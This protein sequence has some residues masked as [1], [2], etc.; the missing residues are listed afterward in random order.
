M[1]CCSDPLRACHHSFPQAHSCGAFIALH[2]KLSR[3]YHSLCPRPIEAYH[4]LLFLCP[5]PDDA[6]PVFSQ[7]S[8]GKCSVC[9]YVSGRYR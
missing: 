9:V 3:D 6:Q 1:L 2:L 7:V 5:L 4:S 8:A